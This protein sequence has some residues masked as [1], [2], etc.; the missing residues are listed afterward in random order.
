MSGKRYT[1]SVELLTQLT[2]VEPDGTMCWVEEVDLMYVF[3][4]GGW[5]SMVTDATDVFAI[6]TFDEEK[7]IDVLD[8]GET[9][10]NV[11]TLVTPSRVAGKYLLAF[12][13]TYHFDR[14]TES[15]FLRWRQDGGAWQEYT[16]EPKD[17]TDAQTSFYSFPKDY[18]AQVHTIDVEMRK[19][20]A[21]GTL[22]MN[23]LDIYLQRV[24]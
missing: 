2:V 22:D 18:P 1:M 13:L 3:K 21:N 9:Y 4:N 23:F 24:G 7:S 11:G 15:V 16:A 10:E 6:I 17:I 19:E 5:T 8:I 12:S 20:T 14:T